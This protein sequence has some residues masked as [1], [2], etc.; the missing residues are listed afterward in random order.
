MEFQ[1]QISQFLYP[2]YLYKQLQCSIQLKELKGELS[3]NNI[4]CVSL[5]KYVF[6]EKNCTVI[7]ELAR[8]I[9]TYREEINKNIFYYQHDIYKLCYTYI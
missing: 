9:V 1:P 7:L 3:I 8:L 5:T 4:Y 2:I 6:L